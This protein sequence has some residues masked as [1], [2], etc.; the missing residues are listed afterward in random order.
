MINKKEYQ[1]SNYTEADTKVNIFVDSIV[2][3]VRI[4]YN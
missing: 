4:E 2:G 3:K 1:S